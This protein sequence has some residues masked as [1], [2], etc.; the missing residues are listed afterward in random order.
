VAHL[1]AVKTS[2]LDHNRAEIIAEGIDDCCAHTSE[3]GICNAVGRLAAAA[4]PF[5]V[6]PLYN[7][8]GVVGVATLLGAILTIQAVIVAGLGIETN[9]RSL[10]AL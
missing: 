4:M 1:C 7:N 2:I 3:A 5:A 9:E 8:F 6:V 10:E